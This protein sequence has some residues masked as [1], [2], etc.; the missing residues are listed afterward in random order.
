MLPI[1]RTR[2]AENGNI[3]ITFVEFQSSD[4]TNTQLAYYIPYA[5]TMIAPFFNCSCLVQQKLRRALR[6]R[7]NLQVRN[8]STLEK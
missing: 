5:G 4:D 1:L 7:Y 8:I 6:T 3:T 2:L